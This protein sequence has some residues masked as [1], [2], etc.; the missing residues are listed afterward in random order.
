MDG[1]R[2]VEEETMKSMDLSKRSPRPRRK[3][4]RAVS[5]YLSG[6]IG[7]LFR[8]AMVLAATAGAIAGLLFGLSDWSSGPCR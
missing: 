2:P 6:L 5:G 8:L 4:E 7:H 3:K 1:V